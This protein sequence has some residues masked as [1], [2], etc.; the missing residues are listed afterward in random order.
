MVGSFPVACQSVDRHR[1]LLVSHPGSPDR[2]R[3][4]PLR[5]SVRTSSA[6][7]R[8]S[9]RPQVERDLGPSDHSNGPPA[10]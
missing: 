8:W 4:A 1:R 10:R 5:G 6:F 9:L 3:R 2:D 7:S